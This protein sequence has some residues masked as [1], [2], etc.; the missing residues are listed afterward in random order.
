M[1]TS[2]SPEELKKEIESG[3]PLTILD[4]REEWEFESGHIKDAVNI[5]VRELGKV[6]RQIKKEIPVVTVC[7]HGVRGEYARK[8]L[9]KLGYKVRNLS[10]GMDAWRRAKQ[11]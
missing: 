9:D 4:V 11:A 7:E 10:G 8:V 1:Q 2:L 3:K 5:S 6:P